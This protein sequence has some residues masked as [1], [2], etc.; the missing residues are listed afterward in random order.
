MKSYCL[1][2]TAV[3]TD[4]GG[5]CGH[6]QTH[7]ISLGT[8]ELGKFCPSQSLFEQSSEHAR[9]QL[10]WGLGRA[11]T[12]PGLGEHTSVPVGARARAS[13][14]WAG[15]LRDISETSN[16]NGTWEV[17]KMKPVNQSKYKAL[18]F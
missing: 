10:G 8:R 13:R 18:S 7:L 14:S 9:L 15:S 12:A 16:S 17:E 1:P 5:N 4:V 11:G 3:L 6:H 2:Y